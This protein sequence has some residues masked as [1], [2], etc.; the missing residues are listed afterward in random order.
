GQVYDRSGLV[1]ATLYLLYPPL[2]GVNWYDFHPEC[3][4]PVLMI[5]AFYYF[6]KGKFVRYFILIVL[7]MMCKEIIPL[8]IVFMG[9]YGLWINRK[10]ILALSILNVKQLLMD[11]GI[12]SS[13]LTVI[14]G[15]AWYIQAGRII[16]SLRGGAYNPFNTWFYL[17]GNIQDIFLSF[18]T[19][20]LYIL[21]IAFT[22]FYSKIFYL[23]VLFGPLAFLSFLNL[24]SLLISIPW[25]AP[26][27]LSLLPNH[28]QPVG[29]QYPALLIPFI[30]ISAIYGTK[31]VILMIENPRLQAFLKNP[32][33]G[34][35][36]KNRYTPGKVLQS[37]NK[38]LDSI[39]ILLLVCSITFFLILSPIGTF[40]NVTFHDKALEMVVNTIPPH[41]SVATQNEI[42]P[43]L[44]HNLNAYPVYHPIFEYEY[45]L[46]D[47]TSIY[48]YLPP[49]YGKYSSP[50]LPVAFSLVVP[51]L[52][53]NGTYGVLI[54]I[55]GIMLL[56]RGYTGQPIIN[57]TLL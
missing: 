30:F 11:K 35:T 25:L 45:I 42:F 19:K 39:L 43:H 46:V 55:D 28:Y 38:P 29:F 10:K 27:M 20:P 50:V 52:I 37:I 57:L 18:I 51:E 9:I 24:P 22:P 31:T 56:K 17:G 14:A 36:I 33:T 13:I 8:I 12:I 16:S 34:R 32:I 3:L 53:D 40:P 5:A 41:S 23:L 54:S 49:I 6:R 1:F 48:Y 2:Q 15:S 7:A 4:F 44:S 47:K 21:Q 26:S